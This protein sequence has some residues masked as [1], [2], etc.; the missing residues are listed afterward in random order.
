M[1]QKIGDLPKERNLP[2][3]PPFTK[4]GVDSFGPIIVKGRGRV[5]RHG[6]IFTCL[7][8]DACIYALHRLISKREQVE[9]R[10]SD[11]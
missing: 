8:T 11:N 1:W 3:H 9:H 10:L 5:K 4:T 6:V 2:D 7:D